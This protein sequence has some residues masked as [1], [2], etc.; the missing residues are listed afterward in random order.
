MT[1]SHLSFGENGMT[2]KGAGRQAT[3]YPVFLLIGKVC[4]DRTVLSVRV[5]DIF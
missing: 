4:P 1:V 2:K 5:G 3:A